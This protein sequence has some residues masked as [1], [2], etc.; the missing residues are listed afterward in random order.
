MAAPHRERSYPCRGRLRRAGRSCRAWRRRRSG[1]TAAPTS[2]SGNVCS[3]GTTIAA[4]GEQ[5]Q[6]GRVES[7][8]DERLLLERPRAQGRGVDARARTASAWKSIS[9]RA[10]APV[11][12]TTS[13]PPA[14]S[15]AGS[16]A[17]SSPP[18]S[19]RM[20]RTAPRRR[21]HP[22]PAR[23][24]R[25]RGRARCSARTVATTV[26]PATRPS[27]TAATPTPPAAPLDE[28]P[29]ADR[30]LG[31]GERP[32][33]ARSR[34]PRRSRRHSGQSTLPGTGRACRSCVSASSAWP[35]PPTR[36]ITGSPAANRSTPGPVAATSP[37]SSS[38]GMSA[39]ASG[40]A[41]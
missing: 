14:P 41:G 19:S 22:T 23:R 33:R 27:C 39:G 18:T 21:A 9:A 37:A 36:A 34:T 25:R 6:D 35:P 5:R 4:V 28:Q 38:P 11:P 15:R 10:P 16:R 24:A 32:H 17:S 3:T 2:T 31:L 40:G 26:A 12:I 8:D 29:L 7:L 20:T 1:R 30:E 13:L